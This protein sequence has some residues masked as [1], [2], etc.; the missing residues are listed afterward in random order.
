MRATTHLAESPVFDEDGLLCNPAHWNEALAQTIA[1]R[2][3]IGQLA[4]AHWKVIRTLRQHYARFGA[5]P[6]MIQVC[7][8]HHQGPHW[9][10]DLFHT[11]L[12]AWR[13]A[14]LPNPGE[15]AKTYLSG[16]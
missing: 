6:A 12:N 15:E 2:L 9:V 5:A 11:C 3:G 16:S 1:D 8:L 4:D 13:V 10:H 14:G 7:R